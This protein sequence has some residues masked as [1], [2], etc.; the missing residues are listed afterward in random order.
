MGWSD[1]DWK[2]G[3]AS[4][5]AHVAAADIRK[6]LD[7]EEVCVLAD[8]AH[9]PTP[10]PTALA[11]E[12]DALEMFN[13]SMHALPI[14]RQRTARQSANSPRSW[15]GSRIWMAGSS[16]PHAHRVALLAA[17]ARQVEHHSFEPPELLVGELEAEVVLRVVEEHPQPVD[18]RRDGHLPSSMAHAARGRCW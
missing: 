13:L 10:A 1:P 3:Y 14:N 9:L 16:R 8:A 17:R 12:A 18:A 7:T 5:A 2:W 6:R 4:G 15:Q 11:P